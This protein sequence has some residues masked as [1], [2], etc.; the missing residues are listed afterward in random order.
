MTSLLADDPMTATIERVVTGRRL[1]ARRRRLAMGGLAVAAFVL[2]ALSLMM[3]HTWYGPDEVLR[4]ILGESVPGAS[5]TVGVLRL[6]RATMGVFVGACFGMSGV[7]FQTL[8]R[9]Q[10][11]AP[12]IIGISSGASAA[13]VFAI[14]VLSWP[15]TT[16]SMFAIVAALVT[17]LTIYLLATKDGVVG[18]RLILV[19]IAVRAMLDSVVAYVLVRAAEWDLQVAMR[20]LTG[21]LNSATWDQV[22]P[23]AVASAVLGP[24]LLA[25]GR[26]L[27]VLRHGP[28]A[29][30]ALG[31]GVGRTNV[32]VILAAVGLIAFAT[33]A[34][35]H[36]IGRD[37]RVEHVF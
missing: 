28:D 37:S 10:L 14:V 21:S 20:W 35:G 8:L 26:D 3:G 13:A 32:A 16:V 31:V 27:E 19:G 9:N 4:V 15:S 23:L 11:A 33:A 12:D 36:F 18:T 5:F 34:A 6:P 25:K 2:F 7:T 29:A 22:L 1:R 24:L 30:T 17:A